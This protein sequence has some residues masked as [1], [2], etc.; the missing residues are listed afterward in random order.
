MNRRRGL[1]AC[2]AA[3]LAYCGLAQAREPFV[4][5]SFNQ[6]ALARHA[7]LPAPQAATPRAGSRIVFDW[8]N[9]SLLEQRG[10]ETLRLDGEAL[11]IGVEQRWQWGGTLLALELPLLITGGGVLDSMIEDWHDWFGLPN[12][13]REQL[14]RDDYRYQYLRNGAL[15][16]DIDEHGPALGDL[17]VSAARCAP[18]GGCLRAMAQL[19][20]ADADELLGGGLGASLWYER[21]YALGGAQRWTGALAAGAS[22]ID[23]DGPLA[24]LQESVVPFGWLSIGYALT[25]A[26]DAGVQFYGHAP[27]YD[28]SALDALTKSGGQLVFGFRYFGVAGT[29]WRLALQEDLVTQSSPDFVIHVSADW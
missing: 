2:A 21:G 9:E 20:T 1:P 8:T 14:P 26:L 6:G 23:G 28:D 11:R 27:L 19:P 29:Q 10:T 25:D 16:F 7:A 18:A 5:A 15:V 3:V 13:G 12:G 17:R 4:F 24:P 22:A